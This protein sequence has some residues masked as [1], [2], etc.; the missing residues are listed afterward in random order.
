MDAGKIIDMSKRESWPD[1]VL[2][3]KDAMDFHATVMH[4]GIVAGGFAVFSLQ[5]GIPVTNDL[6]PSRGAA[7]RIA[8]KS[9]T[10]A[11]LI[12]EAQPDGMTYREADAVLRYERTL[13]AQGFRTP[14]EFET[15]ENSGIL[16]M[17]RTG[18]DRAR[19]IKQLVSGKQI[20]PDNRPYGNLPAAFRRKG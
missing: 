13:F 18:Y 1:P 20:T 11:L 10:D 4:E 9:T 3:V 5:T 6:Y 12:I 7:R 14:D 16:S 8:E 15:E 2:R 17:P 19:M